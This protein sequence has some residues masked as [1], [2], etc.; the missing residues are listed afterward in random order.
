M[1]PRF[2]PAIRLCFVVRASARSPSLHG[3]KPALLAA[4]FAL[5]A[6]GPAR[7]QEMEVEPPLAGRPTEFSQVVGRYRISTQAEPAEVFAE[8]PITLKVR[9]QGEG[10]ARFGPKRAL[11]RIFP[12]DVAEAFHI[13]PVPEQ[14]RVLPREN[15]WEF[16]YRLRP[17]NTEVDALPAL[18]LVYYYVGPQRRGYQTT[19]A[20]PIALVVKP[21]PSSNPAGL[22][23]VVQA[24]ERLY[25]I[26]QGEDVL[27]G[28]QVRS[29]WT[30]YTLAT[31]LVCPPLL[32][33][34]CFWAGR[35]LFPDKVRQSARRRSLAAR[36]A[37][38]EL[39]HVRNPQVPVHAA[40]VL[41]RYLAE[42]LD[43]AGAEPTPVEVAEFLKYK[44]VHPHLLLQWKTFWHACDACKFVPS[45]TAAAAAPEVWTRQAANLML[46]LEADPCLA[47]SR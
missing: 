30:S 20:E 36:R 33:L 21:R 18:R 13:E 34:V 42:R 38:R 43:F 25:D 27:T 23:Q 8:Q 4:L 35:R 41:T 24:P 3:L 1:P 15:A 7:S 16:V 9:I 47:H 19:Y 2:F 37:L 17:K 45:T 46:A 31:L 28:A 5:L 10:P 22:V 32:G 44:G 12:E 40:H 26:I 6:A 39:D 14:D 11:L 29:F